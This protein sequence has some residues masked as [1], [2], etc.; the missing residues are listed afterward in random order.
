M[1]NYI[2]Y[3]IVI[4]A[5]LAAACTSDA[6]SK[7][8]IGDAVTYDYVVKQGDFVV[9]NASLQAGDT[10]TL[11]LEDM[12]VNDPTKKEWVERLMKMSEKDTLSFD[13]KNG[14]KGFLQLHRIIHAKDFPKYIEESDKKQRLFEQNLQSIGKELNAARP[15][16]QSRRQIALDSAKLLFEQYKNGQLANKLMT[17]DADNQY[18]ILKGDG[19]IRNDRKKWVWF[20]YVMYAPDGK[21]LKDSYQGLPRGTNVAEFTFNEAL[22]KSLAHFG[23]GSTVFFSVPAEY[24]SAPATDNNAPVLKKSIY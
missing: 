13:L 7:P 20:H 8:K 5:F 12:N 21:T 15:T 6:T 1:K 24:Q 16:Y 23:E 4:L 14:Q 11:I 9:F 19:K 10:A 3:S 2:L 18:L 17:L 22:E